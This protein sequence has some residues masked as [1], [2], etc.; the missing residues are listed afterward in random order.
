MNF[1]KTNTFSLT[2]EYEAMFL[3]R[4]S[5]RR[6]TNQRHMTNFKVTETEEEE[7]EEEF[8]ALKW[9][10]QSSDQNN[11]GMFWTRISCP[12]ESEQFC[13]NA[14]VKINPVW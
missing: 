10:R 8:K 6:E 7:E 3:Q 14:Q 11:A 1:N 13:M 5:R 4:L 12:A 9:S 2:G